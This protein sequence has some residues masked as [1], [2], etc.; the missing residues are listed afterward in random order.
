MC[1]LFSRVVLG[2]VSPKEYC[3]SGL[4][5]LQFDSY[6][7][8]LQKSVSPQDRKDQGLESLF[9][10]TF[11]FVSSD[12][13]IILEYGGYKI[14]EPVG[15]LEECILSDRTYSVL[16]R[17]TIR[18]VVKE[19][20][21][22]EK[23]EEIKEQDVYFFDLPHM[24]PDGTFVVNGA[25]RVIVSQVHRSPG[26]VFDYGERV[27]LYHSRLIPDKGAWL[28]F[29]ISRDAL[30]A[31]VDRRGRI[32]VSAFLRTLGY[33]TNESILDLFYS[34]EKV[35]VT[36]GEINLQ[37]PLVGRYLRK[38]IKVV[39]KVILAG[40]RLGVAEV[41]QFVEASITEIFVIPYEEVESNFLIIN[42]LERDDLNVE[43]S[44]S[45]VYMMIRGSEP[46]NA[47]S[48]REE[49]ESLFFSVQNY[50]LGPVGRYKINKKF[51]YQ[52]SKTSL[53][54]DREDII[55]TIRYLIKVKA[56]VLPLDDVDHLGNRRVRLIGEQLVGCLRPA[57]LRMQRLARER[58][59]IQDT[60]S[61]SP[62]NILSVRPIVS[63][64]KEFFGMAQLSQFMD[65]TNPL[66]AVTH[67]RRL[68]SL[69]PGGLTRERAGFE[70]RDIHY[71]HYGRVCPIETPEGP[72]IGL[73]V[74]LG[75]YARVNKYGFIESPYFK[76]VDGNVTDEVE[77]LSAIEED[78][79]K[80]SP[81]VDLGEGG[82]ILSE[83]VPVR[84]RGNYE[85]VLRENVDY[86]DVV[87]SQI[88]SISSLLIPF[89]EHDDANRALMGSNMQR[90]SV[91]LLIS[92]SPI[93]GTG[94]ERDVA[95][96][97]GFCVCAKESGEVVYVDSS[98]IVVKEDVSEQVREYFLKKMDRTNQ[99]TCYNQRPTVKKGENV[100]QGQVLS[101]G[102]CIRDGDLSLGRNIFVAFMT[103]EGYNYED[104]VLMSEELIKQDVYTSIHI[105]E[106]EVESRET[107]L[108]REIITSDIPSI[109]EEEL[110]NLDENGV[111]LVGSFVTQGS[112][113]VGK[114]TPKGH[115]EI[116]PEYKL[117]HSIFG[118]KAKD[119]KDTSLRVP[120]GSEGVVIG[121]R[122]YS[123]ENKDSLRPGVVE[124]VKVFLAKKR[125]LTEGD[126]FAGR[127]GNKGVVARILPVEDMP[128]MADGTP[129]QVVLNPL[130]V[131]SR[132]N[133]GQIFELVLGMVGHVSGKKFAVP[134]FSGL[135]YEDINQMIE[136][137]GLPKDSKVPLYDG[138]TG[139]LFKNPVTVGYMYYL[140][141]SHLADEKIHARSTG[142]YSLVTQQP[143]GG[144]AQFG[145][146]RVGEM[147]VWAVEAYGASNLLQEFLTI[148]AD[149]ME[150]R[151]RMYEAIVRGEYM[152]APGVPESFNV[153]IQELKGLALNVEIYDKSGKEVSQMLRRDRDRERKTI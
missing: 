111:I 24:T 150:G 81:S 8:F 16:I 117:L 72:N 138:R 40:V 59:S 31:R 85:V 63:A 120:H 61:L 152:S 126:K 1:Y 118:E 151:T 144:K 98:K 92:E 140:K 22:S 87:A 128:Y 64:I 38:D 4:N 70:V 95:R 135:K 47:K 86:M 109:S 80:I 44:I 149:A 49:I 55:E 35:E 73:I 5:V 14:E 145:G 112:I 56:G 62:Q 121:V 39:D 107:K 91:P 141:L 119:V 3:L 71:T 25:E 46:S 65:Q 125:R 67:K 116:T 69:G 79:Y 58:T 9:R 123:R 10:N 97:S 29:E 20:S 102:P 28:E 13:K 148:K 130:G 11:P 57:F 147:E 133:I 21:D 60:G 127:H 26:V 2:R 54:L 105:E 42:T 90:Q 50:W 7:S 131:P 78:R 84:N 129:V 66:A 139:E 32:P 76:V 45:F 83:V 94:V 88:F 100:V 23:I 153:L 104:A 33:E 124:R 48:A 108:G 137:A 146:Q 99:D 93:V 142:P 18:M 43:N 122:R 15:T 134:V 17:A 41:V 114:V 52:E 74:S 37:S 12:S 75:A 82:K 6:E 110:R 132:M 51:N 113:L 143:L 106:F 53:C 27:N 34:S 36:D 103:W 101:D 96:Y 30:Y 77:F 89:L 136:E 115:T 68:N 19:S